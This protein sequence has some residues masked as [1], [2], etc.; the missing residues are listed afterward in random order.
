VHDIKMDWKRPPF[1]AGTVVAALPGS[2]TVSVDPEFPL[3]GTEFVQGFAE[4]DPKTGL[5][6]LNGTRQQGTVTAV[7]LTGSRQLQLSFA[8]GV[9]LHPGAR[10]LLWHTTA[11]APALHLQSCDMVLL[12]SV[13]LYA[14]P[15]VG[16]LLQGCRDVSLEDVNIAPRPGSKR[17]ASVNG[18]GVM[19]VDCQGA[20]GIKRSSFRGT[21]ADGV[22][23][24]QSLWAIRKRLDD[25]TVLIEGLGGHPL[26]PWQRPEAAS[27]LQLNDGKE[28]TLLGEI[29][30][31]KS[32]NTPDGTQLSFRET[33][34]PLVV[35]G[36]LICNT[37]G[38]PRA[39]I[40]HCTFGGNWDAG[41]AVHGRAR[42]TNCRFT[43]T[44]GAGVRMVADLFAL[45]WPAI[46]SVTVADNVFEGCNVGQVGTSPGT[47]TVDITL[48]GTHE[49]PQKERV[50]Q[51]VTLQRN[52]FS[53]DGR[54]A[55]YCASTSWL[56]VESNVFGHTN[57]AAQPGSAP[58]AIVL[59]NVDQSFL[60]MNQSR[61]E[62]KILLI[63]CTE[64]VQM[65][66]NV[67]LSEVR[68]S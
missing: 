45:Q 17:L 59:R 24:Y 42:I 46:Q 25:R 8:H 34:S 32:E 67:Q 22:N 33:L 12:E 62:Q 29:G 14:A 2:L 53:N 39:A 9:A 21:G 41:I 11:A 36:T 49:A 64:R 15:G 48:R 31:A 10:V 1:S 66:E 44:A 60:E 26:E 50:N 5:P 63:G 27:V 16:A 7:R 58:E 30:L 68:E 57:L 51:G 18:A 19:L 28:L 40:D 54:A 20:V 65:A 55:I 56:T 38:Q 23:I 35:P 3:N 13:A 4:Y 43:G 61:T 52:A 6:V 47:I 37:L